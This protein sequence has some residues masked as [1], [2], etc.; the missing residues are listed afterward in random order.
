M[1]NQ[2]TEARIQQYNADV[3]HLLQQGASRMRD[4]VLI[5]NHKGKA[6]V[7]VDQIGKVEMID[8]TTRH[9]DTPVIETPHT[10]RWV[11]PQHKIVADLIDSQDRLEMQFDPQGPYLQ[12]Q[13]KAAGRKIDSVVLAA[14]IGTSQTGETGAT[15]ETFS[16]TYQIAHG[17]TGLNVDKIKEALRLLAAADVDVDMEQI[18]LAIGSK[19]QKN[20]MDDTQY[21]NLDYV[22]DAVLPN[23]LL[24]P[25]MGVNILR[26]SDNILTV[27]SSIRSCV[28][29]ARSGVHLGIWDDFTASVDKRPDKGNADQVMGKMSI[30][31]TR[32]EQ[33]R[34]IEI[35][36]DET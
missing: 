14:A 32:I 23:G 12:A 15:A 35:L 17:S 26:I 5:G 21:I 36:C 2:V 25:F 24:K 7:A 16:A 33:G 13:A 9:A 11:Y 3:R 29:W 10:R 1:S 27:A 22:S 31:A 28:L 30:G 19:Q 8:V 4:K 6:A 20:L 18:Y 34:V